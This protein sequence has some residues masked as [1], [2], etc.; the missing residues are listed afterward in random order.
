MKS[1]ESFSAGKCLLGPSKEI[2]VGE[3]EVYYINRAAE[4]KN[5]ADIM[6]LQ[7]IQ[8][9]EYAYAVFFNIVALFFLVLVI[10]VVAH[11][12]KGS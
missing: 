11:E 6:N 1:Y 5:A 7:F 10:C 8:R 3:S 2:Y 4:C 9:E 12:A